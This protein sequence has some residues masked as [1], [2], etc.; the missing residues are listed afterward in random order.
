MSTTTLITGANKGLGLETARQ[1]LAAG[2][3]VYIGA[4][5]QAKAE[6]AAQELGSNARPLVIDITDDAS[7]KAAAQQVGTESGALDVLVNNA[8]IADPSDDDGPTGSDM[9]TVL[10]TNVV[11]IVRMMHAFV[12]L[13][14]AGKGVVVNVGSGLGSFGRTTDLSRMEGQFAAPAY[15]A[16][17]AAV[18]MLTVQYAKI[19]PNMRINVVD[20]GFTATDFNGNTGIQ[21]VA[22]GA[23]AIVRAAQIDTDG[24]TS[25]FTDRDGNIPW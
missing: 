20:P 14:Q 18:S 12:P 16:S 11:G 4:R 22:E 1:L 19:Y 15:N 21:T 2:H 3:T 9:L 8:G 7:V 5:S 25:T 23:E 13:L 10:D 17:K 6:Q 24:P